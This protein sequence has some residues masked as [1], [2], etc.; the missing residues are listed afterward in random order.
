MHAAT[1]SAQSRPGIGQADDPRLSRIRR[2]T[3]A[4]QP[5][6]PMTWRVASEI[7]VAMTTTSVSHHDTQATRALLPAR[8]AWWGASAAALGLA[9]NL[10][11]S[12]GS[13]THAG[14]AMSVAESSRS[15]QHVGTLLGMASFACLVLL[16]A[17]WRR[18]AAT[19]S[20]LA[21]HAIAP[22]MT[23]AATLVLLGTGLRGAMA[24]YLPGGINDD[25][26]SDDGLFVLFVLHDTAP[27]FAW[28]GVLLVASLFVALAFRSRVVPR[29]L[30]VVSALVLLPPVGVMVGSGAVAGAGFLAPLWLAIAS[31]T[32]AL[33]GLP[34]GS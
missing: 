28:W 17:G 29:W 14:A 12:H 25:N 34:E 32:V 6:W 9:G 10:I 4:S 2:T 19:A 5:A 24:E 7:F 8:W 21:E 13:L 22:A 18:W 15:A 1:L 30:G 16:T 27:W 3:E 26:F 11:A 31:V 20:G 33:R 23:T